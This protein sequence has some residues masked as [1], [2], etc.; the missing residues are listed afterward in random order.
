[1]F[2]FVILLKRLTT[3]YVMQLFLP[4]GIVVFVAWLSFWFPADAYGLRSGMGKFYDVFASFCLLLPSLKTVGTS[5]FSTYSLFQ[6]QG[7]SLGS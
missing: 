2:Y 3:Y 5:L 4:N 7:T 1:M 6:L